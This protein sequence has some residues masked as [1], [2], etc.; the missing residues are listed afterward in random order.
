V[1]TNDEKDIFE[2]TYDFIEHEILPNK[3]EGHYLIFGRL[4]RYLPFIIEV[5][6]TC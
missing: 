1:K 4:E 2:E 5:S 6:Q 3:L